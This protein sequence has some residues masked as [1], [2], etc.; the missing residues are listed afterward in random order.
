MGAPRL[1]F[2]AAIFLNSLYDDCGLR[3]GIYVACDGFHGVFSFRDL[4]SI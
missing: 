4:L 2:V 1:Y 3:Y